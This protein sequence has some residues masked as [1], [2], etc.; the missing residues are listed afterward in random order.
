MTEFV[1]SLH[2][3]KFCKNKTK[4]TGTPAAGFLHRSAGTIHYISGCRKIMLW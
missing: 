2:D 1:Q 4:Q 3:E